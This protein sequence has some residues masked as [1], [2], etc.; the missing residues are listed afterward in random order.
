MILLFLSSIIVATVATACLEIDMVSEKSTFQGS[1]SEG[2]GAAL[3]YDGDDDLSHLATLSTDGTPKEGMINFSGDYD[4]HNFYISSSSDCVVETV[5]NGSLSDSVMDLYGPN[6]DSLH[7]E[8]DDDGGPGLASLITRA[9]SGAATYYVKVRG[10]GS[11]TGSYQIRATCTSCTPRTGCGTDCGTIPDGCGGTLNCS[12]E[13][14][15]G[16]CQAAN[17]ETPN[18]C[19]SDCCFSFAVSDQGEY[20]PENCPWP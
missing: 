19:P 20:H 7:I 18:S 6:S 17:N 16:I 11:N 15:D 2:I 1:A 4:W 3:S 10:Y 8:Y 12:C 9:L 13:C 5:L 14:G